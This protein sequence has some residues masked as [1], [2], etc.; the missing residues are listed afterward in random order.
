VFDPGD[1]ADMAD[2]KS[3]PGM[4]MRSFSDVECVGDLFDK[5]DLTQEPHSSRDQ[6][7]IPLLQSLDL[8]T[9]RLGMLE[10]FDPTEIQDF[11]EQTTLETPNLLAISTWE[12]GKERKDKDN[13]DKNITGREF[14]A[15]KTRNGILLESNNAKRN[16]SKSRR[17]SLKFPQYFV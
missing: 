4:I 2:A 13:Q 14:R 1:L 5:P 11:C 6:L 12:D 10:F 8:W 9:G 15:K 7:Y 16:P 17:P 3:V